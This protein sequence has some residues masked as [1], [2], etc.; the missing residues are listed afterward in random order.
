[1]SPADS[2]DGQYG[3]V[4]GADESPGTYGFRLDA[5][6]SFQ[7]IRPASFLRAPSRHRAGESCLYLSC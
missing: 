6:R 4:R 7:V 5:S 3:P 1:M 2:R